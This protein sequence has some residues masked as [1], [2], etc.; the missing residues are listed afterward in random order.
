MDETLD[1]RFRNNDDIRLRVGVPGGVSSRDV[2]EIMP[3]Q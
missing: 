2:V 3:G 1:V